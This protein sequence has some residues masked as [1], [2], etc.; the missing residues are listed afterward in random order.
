MKKLGVA[1]CGL[2]GDRVV[3]GV[4]SA[5]AI[6]LE[7]PPASGGSHEAPRHSQEPRSRL[8]EPLCLTREE[9]QSILGAYSNILEGLPEEPVIAVEKTRI[10]A[11]IIR[12]RLRCEMV[13]VVVPFLQEADRQIRKAPG[14]SLVA[15]QDL[16]AGVHRTFNP[17]TD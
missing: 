3:V 6:G 8:L 13:F 10:S 2:M 4:Q 17:D 11:G 16:A 1:L 5:T 14:V 15:D 9:G 7:P 12:D